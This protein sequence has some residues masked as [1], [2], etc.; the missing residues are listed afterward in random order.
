MC[1]LSVRSFDQLAGTARL[2]LSIERADPVFN[3]S[4]A[5]GLEVAAKVA[6]RP[7]SGHQTVRG[8]VAKHFPHAD[9]PAFVDP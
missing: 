2:P 8:G 9:L 4:H 1:L 7:L 6:P 5:D 3:Q